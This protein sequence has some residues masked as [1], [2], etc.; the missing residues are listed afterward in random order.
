MK[1]D[2]QAQA[3]HS[4]RR[5]PDRD[6]AKR[7]K[8]G[9]VF[10]A[11]LVFLATAAFACAWAGAWWAVAAPSLA[12]GFLS[13]QPRR[14][15]L[16][17]A[18]GPSLAWLL[19]AIVA[20]L[21]TGARLSARIA[22]VLQSPAIVAYLISALIAALAGVLAAWIGFELRECIW[23]APQRAVHSGRNSDPWRPVRNPEA[24]TPAD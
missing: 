9:G 8:Q 16:L 12:A 19:S 7:A 21:K 22:G 10:F 1:S 2:A 18:A 11:G 6:P 23:P 17:G 20:D 5:T 13:L 15:L 24:R 4:H 14:A 3:I